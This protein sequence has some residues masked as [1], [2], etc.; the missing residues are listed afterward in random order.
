MER[1]NSAKDLGVVAF[2]V[3]RNGFHHPIEDMKCNRV[4]VED[5]ILEGVYNG[6]LEA[7]NEADVEFV[8]DVVDQ[9]I[10]EYTTSG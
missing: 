9:F 2:D 5:A 1:W 8:C 7:M 3:M 6:F 10:E 4:N